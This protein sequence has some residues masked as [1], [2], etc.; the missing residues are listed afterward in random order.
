MSQQEFDIFKSYKP[1]IVWHP[2]QQCWYVENFNVAKTE[3]ARQARDCA[4][5][6]CRLRNY[7]HKLTA[8]HG[9]SYYAALNMPERKK[10]IKLYE[11]YQILQIKPQGV[12]SWLRV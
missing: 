11:E 10:L 12:K 5:A 4:Q 2:C 6:W 8:E 3:E 7:I 9:E 1:H